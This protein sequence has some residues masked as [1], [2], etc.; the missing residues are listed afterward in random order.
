MKPKTF[1]LQK[2]PGSEMK[3]SCRNI[4]KIINIL[5]KVKINH[6]LPYINLGVLTVY[7][8]FMSNLTIFPYLG[9]RLIPLLEPEKTEYA[10]KL[11]CKLD[12]T[13]SGVNIKVSLAKNA[14]KINA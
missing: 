11:L 13:Y 8:S 6:S 9:A 2:L 10:T 5:S 3:N 7:Y 14:I 4:R 1:S 12:S